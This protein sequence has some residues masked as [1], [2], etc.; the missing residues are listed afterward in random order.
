MNKR[1][2]FVDSDV[3]IS[4]LISEKGAA[5]HLLN[6]V[7]FSFVI[8]NFSQLELENVVDRLNLDRTQLKELIKKKLKIIKL[9]TDLDE[10]K[11][12]FKDYTSDTNDAHIVAGAAKAK[13]KFL[14][15]YNIR[16]FEKQK[17]NEDLGIV[18]LTPAQYLQY[19]RSID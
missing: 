7:K 2:I 14:L 19:L 1:K 16:H 10:A 3:V 17:I 9:T 6:E 8:S 5:Y 13:A 12:R 11:R 15:T 18:V 4:S